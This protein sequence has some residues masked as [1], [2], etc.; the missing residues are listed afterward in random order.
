MAYIK[1]FIIIRCTDDDNI[2]KSRNLQRLFHCVSERDEFGWPK[3]TSKAMEIELRAACV[4]ESTRN[5]IIKE[6]DPEHVG[7]VRLQKNCLVL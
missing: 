6:L 5:K 3:L 1:N 2:I 7:E 4:P